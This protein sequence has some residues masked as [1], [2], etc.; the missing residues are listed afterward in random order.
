MKHETTPSVEAALPTAETAAANP[1]GKSRKPVIALGLLGAC[2]LLVLVIPW[3][4]HSMHTV[5]TDDAYVNSYVTFVAPRVPG[6]VA[7]VLVE[8][9]NRVKKGDVL[10]Q[11]DPE[12]YRIKLAVAEAAL[13]TSRTDLDAAKANTLGLLAL[14]RSARFKLEHAIEDVDNQVALLRARAATLN[15]AIASYVQAVG[16]NAAQTAWAAAGS[17]AARYPRAADGPNGWLGSARQG[18]HHRR[19]K[20]RNAGRGRSEARAKRSTAQPARHDW[21]ADALPT[22]PLWCRCASQNASK[23]EDEPDRD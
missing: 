4:R 6:Q 1:P 8:D 13:E 21:R 23:Q 22:R 7:R 17:D 15:M 16:T 14:S 2:A 18:E 9:N 11:L 19:V 5:S 20:L 3:I 10:V 12:P